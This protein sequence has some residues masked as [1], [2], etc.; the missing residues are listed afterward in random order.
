MIEHYARR[1]RHGHIGTEHLLYGLRTVGGAAIST[2][3]LARGPEKTVIEDQILRYIGEGNTGLDSPIHY[4]EEL[5]QLCDQAVG[6][7]DQRQLPYVGTEVLLFIL[8]TMRYKGG[9]CD[10]RRILELCH[11]SIENLATSTMV[12]IEAGD[13][14]EPPAVERSFSGA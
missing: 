10:G 13:Y 12:Y 7:K 2:L 6:L 5:K 4:T 11:C 3:V 1:F 14:R 9:R 8:L